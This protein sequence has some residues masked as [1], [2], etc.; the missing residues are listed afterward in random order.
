MA[1]DPDI[2]TLTLAQNSL[3]RTA[4]IDATGE[5]LYVTHTD[6]SKRVWRTH[7]LEGPVHSGPVAAELHWTANGWTTSH[8]HAPRGKWIAMWR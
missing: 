2:S 4:I 5:V 7:I 3:G 6:V 1:N 8:G